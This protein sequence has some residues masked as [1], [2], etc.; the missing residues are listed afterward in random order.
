MSLDM[1]LLAALGLWLDAF[2]FVLS[3]CRAAQAG[4][5]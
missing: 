3:C 4:S 1:A 2:P 5:P